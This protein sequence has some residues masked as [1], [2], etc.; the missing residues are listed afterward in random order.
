MMNN[1]DK[2]IKI[3]KVCEKNMILGSQEHYIKIICELM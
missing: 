1:D 3:E 2:T